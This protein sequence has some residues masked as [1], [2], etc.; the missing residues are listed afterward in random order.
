MLN[1]RDRHLL[2][3]IERQ[4]EREDPAWVRQFN[5]FTS[6]RRTRRNLLFETAIGMLV[7]LAALCLV[8]GATAAVVPFVCAAIGVAYVRF[9]R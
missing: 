7:L 9:H 5:A 2:K 3:D 6:P 8:S 1:D 4:L